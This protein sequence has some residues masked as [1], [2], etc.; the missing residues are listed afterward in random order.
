MET[1]THIY[2]ATER[3]TPLGAVLQHWEEGKV[4]KGD[5]ETRRRGQDEWLAW[6]LKS[7]AV[8]PFSTSARQKITA[9]PHFNRPH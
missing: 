6:G 7:I 5:P 8:S 9:E 2:I 4:V 1:E 3:V